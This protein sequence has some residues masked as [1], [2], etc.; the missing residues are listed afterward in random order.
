[1][2]YFYKFNYLDTLFE[3]FFSYIPNTKRLS[4][5][6]IAISIIGGQYVWSNNPVQTASNIKTV[7]LYKK[8]WSMS[9]PIIN[10]YPQEQLTLEFDDFAYD[11][12]N[13]QYSII[14]CNSNWE[15]SNLMQ[16]EY[17]DGFM[18]NAIQDYQYS[19]NT[20]FDYIHYTLDFPNRD[21]KLLLSGNYIIKV[22]ELGNEDNPILVRPF[23]VSESLVSIL[24]R[25]KYT[26]N[27]NFRASMQE[28]NFTIEHPNF[29]INNPRD[30][31]KVVLQQN[32]R[33]DNQIDD[34]KPLF[35]RHE[36]LD[37]SY[38]RENLFDGGNEY[39]W[40]DIRSTRFA[41]EHVEGISFFD[42]H[43]HFTLFPDKYLSQKPY[44]YR[45]DFNGK[46]YIE[47]KEN[48]DPMI[49]ADYTYVHFKF[50]V[51]APYVDGHIY[52]TGGLNDW[53]LNDA[54]RM[55][56]NFTTRMYEL[57]M[58]LKQGFYNYQYHFL[59]NNFTK[60]E[61]ERFEGSFGQTENDY[62]I[63][64]YYQSVGDNYER[65]IGVNISNSLKYSMKK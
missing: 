15:E 5:A 23:Y 48:R 60:A 1:M 65:L 38:N 37:Y 33:W 42:P 24:P 31:I 18:P 19:F 43:Y 11:S 55:E 64:V 34:L 40:L 32:G 46:Y 14:H 30:E 61:V 51:K 6:F 3:I 17:V 26:S 8:G 27:S 44:F 35:I 62:I 58:L 56:Y 25:I 29:R 21:I 4:I 9:Y 50:P 12:K 10:L 45:E 39:R 52:V 7:Q 16:T 20:T 2:V 53:Q 28:V 36:E 49:E 22:F 41:P 47:V 59:E 57:S 54:N 63:Y 13:Y